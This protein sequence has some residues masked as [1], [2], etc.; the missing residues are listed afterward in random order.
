MPLGQIP[1]NSWW[2][3]AT[4][5]ALAGVMGSSVAGSAAGNAAQVTAQLDFVND[6]SLPEGASVPAQWLNEKASRD[7]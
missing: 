6:L 2:R 5:F 3:A 7:P 4:A 1:I